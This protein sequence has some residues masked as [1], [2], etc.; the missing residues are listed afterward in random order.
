MALHFTASPL[1]DETGVLAT[2]TTD[3]RVTL[4]SEKI[5][6]RTSKDPMKPCQVSRFGTE[7]TEQMSMGHLP[8]TFEFDEVVLSGFFEFLDFLDAIRSRGVARNWSVMGRF[9]TA[10]C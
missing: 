1:A 4:A 5:H 10:I 6:D 9:F 3:D 8:G 7:P 2:A